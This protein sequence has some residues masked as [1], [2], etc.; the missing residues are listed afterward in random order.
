MLAVA[1]APK[2]RD[3]GKACVACRLDID[4]A[5][6]YIDSLLF[7]R[8]K[9]VQGKFHHVRSR[10]QGNAWSLTDG[11]IY[12]I[13][14]DEF[15]VLLEKA[16]WYDMEKYF[17]KFDKAIDQYNSEHQTDNRLSVSK[18]VATFDAEKHRSYR[19]VF[20]EAKADCDQNKIRFY[21]DTR[22]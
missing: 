8:S 18:G 1:E 12:H 2:D 10:L 6:A 17:E 16:N 5:I 22:K 11:N 14:G 13:T 9:F 4:I 7:C 21:K 3:A 19:Q 15:I 20:I